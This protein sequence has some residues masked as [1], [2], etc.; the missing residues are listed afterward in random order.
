[1]HRSFFI[2]LLSTT[3]AVQSFSEEVSQPKK[4]FPILKTTDGVELRDVTVTAI[5]QAGVALSH[6][7]G[8]G[9]FAW[10]R[11]PK[12]DQVAMGF[13]ADKIATEQ[14]ASKEKETLR[15]LAREAVVAKRL[16]ELKAQLQSKVLTIQHLAK[17]L[18]EARDLTPPPAPACPSSSPAP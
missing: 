11:I 2:A 17:L 13:N 1:M 14:S 3:F 10:S 16:P 5:D 15:K 6:S 9:R 18:V 8:T 4:T 12:A 7:D